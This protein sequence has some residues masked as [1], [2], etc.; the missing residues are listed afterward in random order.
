MSPRVLEVA[1]VVLGMFSSAALIV[2]GVI[3]AG[4]QSGSPALFWVILALIL[5]VIWWDLLSHV[6]RIRSRAFADANRARRPEMFRARP[7]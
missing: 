4:R 2:L 7:P 3:V 1:G 6:R 5:G